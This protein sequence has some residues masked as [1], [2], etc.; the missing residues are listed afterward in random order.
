M[1]FPADDALG[2]SDEPAPPPAKYLVSVTGPGS[3][4]GAAP[5]LKNVFDTKLPGPPELPTL[6]AG[7][8]ITATPPAPPPPPPALLFPGGPV[9][10]F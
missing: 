4:K 6:G 9:V 3:P 7:L 1:G 10:P 5:P 8:P 2:P